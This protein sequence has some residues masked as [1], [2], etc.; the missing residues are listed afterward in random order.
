ME[1]TFL[2]RQS[3]AIKAENKDQ[4]LD[5][6]FQEHWR[7]LCNIL[8]RIVGDW[9]EAEDLALQVFLQ[10]SRRPPSHDQNLAGWLYR[11]AA[12]LGFNALRARQRRS[13]YEN[14]AAEISSQNSSPQDPAAIYEQEQERQ[15]VRTALSA[16]KTRSA[17]VLI[18]RHSGL[19]YSEIAAALDISPN[20]VGTLLARAGREFEKQYQ[21]LENPNYKTSFPTQGDAD[22][23]HD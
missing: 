3:Q 13:K 1:M 16:M 11:V 5:A 10:F 7:R 6:L 22:E 17:Q 15:Q 23:T 8:F 18:L 19:S 21:R 2:K 14:Q 9:A 12:N 4:L 20:S